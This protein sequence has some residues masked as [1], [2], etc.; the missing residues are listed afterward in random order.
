MIKKFFYA[1]II[2]LAVLLGLTF[3]LHN[4]E[5]VTLQYYFGIEL[6]GALSL[7]ILISFALGVGAGYMANLKTLLGL[8]RKLVKTRRDVQQAEQEVANIRALPIKDAL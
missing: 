2:L 4:A 3:T 8:Q 1:V 7:V 6:Q 5:P